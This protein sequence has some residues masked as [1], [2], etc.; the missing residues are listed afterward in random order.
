MVSVN[1]TR[2]QKIVELLSAGEREFADLRD[3]LGVP[4]HVLEEDLQHVERS[5][6]ARAHRLRVRPAR[7]ASCGFAFTSTALHPPGRCPSCRG[8]QIMGP[9]LR[10][11]MP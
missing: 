11:T 9:W 3:E 10:V 1:A 5:I 8:S 4:V 2:R 7:C 6:R